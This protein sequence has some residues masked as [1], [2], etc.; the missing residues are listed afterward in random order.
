MQLCWVLAHQELQHSEAPAGVSVAVYVAVRNQPLQVIEGT[1][2]QQAGQS[3]GSHLGLHFGHTP[4]KGVHLEHVN[5]IGSLDHQE[6]P[7]R[8][9]DLLHVRLLGFINPISHL[10]CFPQH[11]RQA[12]GQ[13]GI[14][15]FA[16]IGSCALL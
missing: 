10:P 3:L 11:V 16:D 12:R 8:A 1:A 4:E 13:A 6:A 7:Y 5:W 2:T 14:P 15:V 9:S